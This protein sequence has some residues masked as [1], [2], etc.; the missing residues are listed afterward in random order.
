M[1]GEETT[2]GSP[3]STRLSLSVTQTT[4]FVSRP[5]STWAAWAAAHEPHSIPSWSVISTSSLWSSPWNLA[6]CGTSR[7]NYSESP[8]WSDSSWQNLLAAGNGRAWQFQFSADFALAR[9]MATERCPWALSRMAA[10][11]PRVVRPLS[12]C[13]PEGKV[14]GIASLLAP[15]CFIS[16]QPRL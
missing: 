16:I 8:H 13:F 6:I 1:T 10:F 9:W 4:G 14:L 7:Q 11:C 2:L 15:S 5:S 3:L 12:L